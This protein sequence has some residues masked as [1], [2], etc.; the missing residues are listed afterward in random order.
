MA[1][2]SGIVGCVVLCWPRAPNVKNHLIWLMC[3]DREMAK[4]EAYLNKEECFNISAIVKPRTRLAYP[5]KK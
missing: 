1:A 5:M 2:A 3:R 4:F